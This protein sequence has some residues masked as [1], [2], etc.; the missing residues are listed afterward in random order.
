M[1]RRI[2]EIGQVR[3]LLVD[4]IT[5][6]TDADAG[7]FA[8]SGS[9]GGVSSAGYALRAPLLGVAFNDAGG[10]KN[11][12]GIAGLA[13]LDDAGMAAVMVGH[14][15]AMIGHASDTL[16]SGVI[17]HVNAAA[18]AKGLVVGERLREALERLG[19]G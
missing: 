5:E 2:V 8:V 16:E 14:M 3:V 15:S 4:S 13:I 1:A 10:G 12:A 17:S 19:S 11:G 6:V 7:T 9:H 18:A